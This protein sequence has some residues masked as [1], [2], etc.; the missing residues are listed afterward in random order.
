MILDRLIESVMDKYGIETEDIEKVKKII[1][2]VRF[3]KRNGDDYMIIDI[4]EGVEL[5]IKQKSQ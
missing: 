1:R 3:T 2:K 4:G 5:S